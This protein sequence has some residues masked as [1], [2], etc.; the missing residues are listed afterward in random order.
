MTK[1]YESEPGDVAVHAA[2]GLT[3]IHRS[4]GVGKRVEIG[5]VPSELG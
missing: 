3:S 5:E 4:L 1:V 2:P